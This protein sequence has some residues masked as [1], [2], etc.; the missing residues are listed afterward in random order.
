MEA[1]Y[2]SFRLLT[3]VFSFCREVPKIEGAGIEDQDAWTTDEGS[4]R[5]EVSIIWIACFTVV[6]DAELER[7]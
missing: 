7:H 6:D 4:F 5:S 2:F 3:S 1:S